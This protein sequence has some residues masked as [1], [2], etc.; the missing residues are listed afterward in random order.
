[1]V[2]PAG[3]VQSANCPLL[4][5]L[6]EKVPGFV[7]FK[8]NHDSSLGEYSYGFVLNRAPRLPLPVLPNNLMV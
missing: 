3:K 7:L 5:G 8:P 2:A 1:M 6:S 4:D